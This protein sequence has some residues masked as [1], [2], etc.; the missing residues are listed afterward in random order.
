M[1]TWIAVGGLITLLGMGIEFV[2]I[3]SLLSHQLRMAL[4]FKSPSFALQSIGAICGVLG[5]LII[6]L[7]KFL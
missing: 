7:C 3:A 6:V 4:P 5:V 2:G 1:K